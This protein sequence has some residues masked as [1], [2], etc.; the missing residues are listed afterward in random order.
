[1]TSSKVV[2][3]KKWSWPRNPIYYTNFVPKEI[4]RLP[5]SITTREHWKANEYKTFVLYYSLI[6]LQGILPLPYFLFVWS[7]HKLLST[8]ISPD[9]LMKVKAALDFFIVKM[10]EHYGIGSCTFN[11][12]QLSHLARS[13]EMCGPLWAVSTFTFEGKNSTLKKNDPRNT[14]CVRSGVPNICYHENLA[15]HHETKYPRK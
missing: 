15:R 11:I 4:R 14:V 8:C 9:D 12:H 3:N 10:E 6:I 7:L 13:T 1:M 2:E 5:R